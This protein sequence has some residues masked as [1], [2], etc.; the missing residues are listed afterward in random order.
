MKGVSQIKRHLIA[1]LLVGVLLLALG[2]AA[3]ACSSDDDTQDGPG[4]DSQPVEQLTLEEYIVRL[5]MVAREDKAREAT[6]TESCAIQAD[7]V[8]VIGLNRA[9]EI[10]VRGWKLGVENTKNDLDVLGPPPEVE[11]LHNELLATYDTVAATIEEQLGTVDEIERFEEL[12]D[13]TVELSSG[14]LDASS[15]IEAVCAALQ[16]VP[17][18]NGVDFDCEFR[19]WPFFIP[20]FLEG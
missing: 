20:G 10:C 3:A 15:R 2:I 7:S 8:T 13:W 18:E 4:Q 19:P 16:D 1:P 12:R 14:F 11:D 17:R 9:I 5:D 6:D